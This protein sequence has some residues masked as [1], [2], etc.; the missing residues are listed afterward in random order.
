MKKSILLLL[1]SFYLI[2][3]KSQTQ[4]EYTGI[5]N[6]SIR[7]AGDVFLFDSELIFT[8]T[9]SSFVYK[10]YKNTKWLREAEDELKGQTIYTDSNGYQIFTDLISKKLVVREFCSEKQAF[11]Y[12]DKVNIKWQLENEQK[13]I[14]GLKCAKASTHFRGRNYTAWYALEV[15]SS[16]GPW[17]FNGLPGLIVKVEESKN[18]VFIVLKSL[19]IATQTK[20]PKLAHGTETSLKE[21]LKNMDAAYKEAVVKNE[22]AI[23]Q[24]QAEFPD[25][26][27]NNNMPVKRPATELEFE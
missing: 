11:I 16:A 20:M 7:L 12:K 24:L 3:A 19:K 27:I 23:S 1:I 22:V 21:F 4:A 8:D 13:E 14:E 2:N 15:P 9:K 18:E 25:L 5:A 17:K 10:K 26:E 6:Y